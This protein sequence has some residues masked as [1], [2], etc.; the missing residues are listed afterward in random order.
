MKQKFYPLFSFYMKH[1]TQDLTP[2]EK[3]EKFIIYNF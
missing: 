3:Y 1:Y 2:K